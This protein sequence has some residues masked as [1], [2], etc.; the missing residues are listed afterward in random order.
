MFAVC[1][2]TQIAVCISLL[3]GGKYMEF[4][5][6][7]SLQSSISINTF[8]FDRPSDSLYNAVVKPK[9]KCPSTRNG[10]ARRCLGEYCY[11]GAYI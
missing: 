5:I 2:W 4:R 8:E 11:Q 9:N 6:I 1:A 10:P 7:F 3:F